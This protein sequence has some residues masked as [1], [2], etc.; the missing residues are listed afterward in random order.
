[1]SSYA[2]DDDSFE[3]EDYRRYKDRKYKEL[4]PRKDGVLSFIS[5]TETVVARFKESDEPLPP[6]KINS[7][8]GRLRTAV[9]KLSSET[10]EEIGSREL[11]QWQYARPNERWF[12]DEY[13]R[14][15]K[16]IK[17]N[18]S[19]LDLL[20]KLVADDFKRKDDRDAVKRVNLI[21]GAAFIFT[22][23]GGKIEA[24]RNSPFVKYLDFLFLDVGMEQADV[25]KA[26]R[27]F[28]KKNSGV[29]D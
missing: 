11:L 17:D 25:P 13:F 2:N 24:G 15:G 22:T 9:S 1:M 20:E 29:L 5:S 14:K 21:S 12:D 7:E 6:R 19:A 16:L 8:L 4:C 3:A 10:R 28:V 27:D 23:H 26:V 18:G